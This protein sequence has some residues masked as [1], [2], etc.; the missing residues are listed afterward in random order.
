MSLK[1]L[2]V[3]ASGAALLAGAASAQTL[4]FTADPANN[5][6]VAEELSFANGA[7]FGDLPPVTAMTVADLPQNNGFLVQVNLTGSA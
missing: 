6:D 3:A 5:I 7:V 4:T 2:A 1:K